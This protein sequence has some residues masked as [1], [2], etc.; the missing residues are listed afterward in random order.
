MQTASGK[1]YDLV[2]SVAR[3]FVT[4][5]SCAD[6]A[7]L[8]EALQAVETMVDMMQGPCVENI[9]VI[10]NAKVVDACKRVLAWTDMDLSVG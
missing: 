2:T 5:E 6:E 8:R 4:L 1:S 7:G 10:V 3:Y 9:N